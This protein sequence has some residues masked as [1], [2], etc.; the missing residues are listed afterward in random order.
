MPKVQIQTAKWLVTPVTKTE[1]HRIPEAQNKN[2]HLDNPY[3]VG[4]R[5]GHLWKRLRSKTELTAPS[6]WSQQ[7]VSETENLHRSNVCLW[8]ISRVSPVS[9]RC[10]S[11]VKGGHAWNRGEDCCF[12][13]YWCTAGAF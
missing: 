6:Q 3:N 11:L 7:T 4:K 8:E 13:D 1:S 9:F 5:K 2:K 12:H 10:L